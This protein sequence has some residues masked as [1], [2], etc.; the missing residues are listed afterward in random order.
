L[1]DAPRGVSGFVVL[2]GEK[3]KNWPSPGEK[4]RVALD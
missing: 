1:H 4:S 3:K 2:K